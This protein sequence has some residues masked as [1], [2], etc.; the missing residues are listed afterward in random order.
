MGNVTARVIH[1]DMRRTGWFET[2]DLLL[3]RL[4]DN[5]VWS[6]RGNFVDLPTDCPNRDERLGWTGDIQ[7]FTPT[8]SFLYD[9]AGLLSSWLKDVAAEQHQDGTVPW[10]VPEIPGGEQWTPARPGAGWGDAAVIVPWSLHQNFADTGLVQKQYNSARA[11]ADL[12]HRLASP[13][14]VW[15]QSYQLG[16]W[17]DPTA[18]PEDPA[19][20][21]TDPNLVATAYYAR[22]TATVADMAHLLNR[23]EAPELAERAKAA[24]AGFRNRYLTGHGTLS[25]DSQAAYAIAIV[26]ELFDVDEM[27]TA[28]RRLGG[29]VYEADVHLTTGFLGTPVLLDALTHTGHFDV[30]MQLMQQRTVPSWIYPVTMGAT[31][32]WER[33]DSMLPNGEVNPGDMTSFNHFAFGSVADW[34]HR[35]I[36]GIRPITPGWQQIAYR[37]GLESGLKHASASHDTPYGLA[38]ISWRRTLNTVKID[39]RV[40]VGVIGLLEQS[41]GTREPL[42][43]GRHTFTWPVQP[44]PILTRTGKQLTELPAHSR[45]SEP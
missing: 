7:V 29:L 32:I 27:K 30:A 20:G 39:V 5:V 15:E 43:P 3:N 23:P 45:A 19:R 9:C 11:W 18:P 24:R 13:A 42:A 44:N 17:L 12:V 25:S 38:S 41:D 6:M 16:D 28:G 8:A 37:P 14:H 36:A 1:T 2:S 31:T 35:T 4:H 22:S 34:M 40:P 33:W 10:F 21:L 26:F